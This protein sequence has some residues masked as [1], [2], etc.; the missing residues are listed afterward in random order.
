MLTCLLG[1]CT[2]NG[3]LLRQCCMSTTPAGPMRLQLGLVLILAAAGTGARL[4]GIACP[5]SLLLRPATGTVASLHCR[6]LAMTVNF[7]PADGDHRANRSLAG[8]LALGDV[9]LR[10]RPASIQQQT[11][12]PVPGLEPFP[13]YTQLSSGFGD[14]AVGVQPLP[15]RPGELAA[16]DIT[17]QLGGARLPLRVQR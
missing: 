12:P 13:H 8:Q 4:Q 6:D 1:L 17:G 7:V 9:S 3:L 2:V 5:L 15:L 11:V 10:I 16:H 14:P